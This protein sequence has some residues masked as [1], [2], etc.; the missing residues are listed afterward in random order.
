MSLMNIAEKGFSFSGLGVVDPL[1][2]ETE[3][4]TSVRTWE[5]DPE[6]IESLKEFN[7]FGC[8]AEFDNFFED[9]LSDSFVGTEN[10]TEKDSAHLGKEESLPPDPGE[11]PDRQ[12]ASTEPALPPSLLKAH[13]SYCFRTVTKAVVPDDTADRTQ[14]WAGYSGEKLPPERE[15]EIDYPSV[16][17]FP[18]VG[19]GNRV[20]RISA[21][22]STWPMSVRRYGS[23]LEHLPTPSAIRAK[24][25]ALALGLRLRED[26]WVHLDFIPESTGMKRGAKW[27]GISANPK[28]VR[29]SNLFPKRGKRNRK[30]KVL[31]SMI[32]PPMGG[33]STNGALPRW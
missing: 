33:F 26:Y 31:P 15:G 10:E 14:T 1:D 27:I 20:Q 16:I 13:A 23:G 28:I 32:D 24:E 17:P 6:Y 12:S 7:E 21:L 30:E 19:K 22:A 9:C 8:D 5:P 4:S 11:R 2:D 25:K 18:C 3:D 29:A